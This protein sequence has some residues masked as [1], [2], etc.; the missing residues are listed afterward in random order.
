MSP[1]PKTEEDERWKLFYEFDFIKTICYYVKYY[2]IR[3]GQQA[4]C[5]LEPFSYTVDLT[6]SDGTMSQ[7]NISEKKLMK[8]NQGISMPK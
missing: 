4:I 3:I 6:N 8:Q 7:Q 1:S 5:L 2:I